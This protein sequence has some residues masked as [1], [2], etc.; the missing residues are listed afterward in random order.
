MGSAAPQSGLQHRQLIVICEQRS[1]HGH[2]H[3]S[4]TT[5][6]IGQTRGCG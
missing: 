6:Q 4:K 1:A 5:A 3:D 2:C